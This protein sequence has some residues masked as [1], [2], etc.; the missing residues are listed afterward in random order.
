[1]AFSFKG[2]IHPRYAKDLAAGAAIEDVPPPSVATVP[3]SQ[4]LGAPAKA[5][6]AK[7]D[8]VLVGQRIGEPAG[9]VSVPVHAPIS[10]TVKDIGL[11]AHPFG[12][13]QEAVVIEADGED[14]LADLAATADP[15]ALGPDE[16]KQKIKD[17]GVVGMGGAAFPTHVKLSPPAGKRIDTA[18]LNGAECEPYLTADDRLMQERADQVVSGFRI[19]MRALGVKEGVIGI[20]ENKPEALRAIEAAVAKAAGSGVRVARLDVKYPQGGEKQLIAA[21]LNREV[22]SGGLP[23]D[24]G[25]VVQNV[26]TCTS[27]DDAVRLGRPLISRI[28]TVTGEGVNRPCNLNVRLGTPVTTLLE[29]AGGYRGTPGRVILG[30]PMMGIAAPSVDV[31]VIKSTGG[32]LVFGRDQLPDPRHQACIRCGHCVRACPMGL[33]PN[34]QGLY[35]EVEQWEV[36]VERDV[37][38]CIECGCCTFSCPANRP[39]VQWFRYA[40]LWDRQRTAA[41]AQA[42]KK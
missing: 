7:G 21:I 42:Q 29:K 5:C 16:V 26:A 12:T 9:F 10:G 4:H 34:E 39:L 40:K 33:C 18:L 1:M 23:M 14:K 27:V 2:G 30:G 24:V 35:A 19:V 3:L 22:P 28:T 41:Q 20:E 36:V 15:L 32:V 38:D 11:Y 25:V 31:P 37:K 13:I 8:H 17:A 6:V